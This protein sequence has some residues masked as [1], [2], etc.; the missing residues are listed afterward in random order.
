VLLATLER[1]TIG[2]EDEG[3]LCVPLEA[4][5]RNE[6]A[7]G[8]AKTAEVRQL[9]QMG[10]E[11]CVLTRSELYRMN[12]RGFGREQVLTLRNFDPSLWIRRE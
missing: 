12:A 6:P 7:R 4:E 1:L 3:A 11:I 2:T 8:T 10:D 9:F 5:N